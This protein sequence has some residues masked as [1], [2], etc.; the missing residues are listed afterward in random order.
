MQVIAQS[1]IHAPSSASSRHCAGGQLRAREIFGRVRDEHLAA[2]G[3]SPARPRSARPRSRVRSRGSRRAR[4]T[5]A[6]TSCVSGRSA[7]VGVGHDDARPGDAELRGDAVVEVLA[8]AQRRQPHDARTQPERD[9]DRGRVHAAD[10]AVAAD[11]AEHRDRVAD[12]RAARPRRA[13]R[14]GSRATSARWR[15]GRRP[16][17]RPPASNASTERS[18]CGSGPKWQCRSAAPVRSTLIAGELTRSL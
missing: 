11:A 8:A 6:R 4:L 13:R 15:D 9:L 10:L 1:S 7:I 12:R 16:R 5:S 3:R 18:R 2:C 14:W 17:L